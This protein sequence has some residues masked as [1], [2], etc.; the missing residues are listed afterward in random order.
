MNE[1]LLSLS[2][3]DP[4]EAIRLANTIDGNENDLILKAAIL[5]DY[6]LAIGDRGSVEEG[7]KITKVILKKHPEN[8]KIQYNLANGLQ[9]LSKVT[10]IDRPDWYLSTHHIRQEARLLFSN[11]VKNASCDSELTT[12]AYTNLGNLL[13]SSYRWVEAFD[14]YNDALKYDINN[15]VASSG[16]A[17]ILKH[18]LDIGVGDPDTIKR[19]INRY[20]NIT[21]KSSGNILKYAGKKACASIKSD[22]GF[23]QISADDTNNVQLGDYESFVA[24]HRLALSL[25]I[26]DANLNTKR[27]DDIV[28]ESILVGKKE[29][30]AVPSTFA[31]FNIMKSD[32]ILARWLTYSALNES[33]PDS[34]KYSDTL[35]YA[36][37]G[38]KYSLLTF[39]QKSAID[40][41]DKLTVAS[42]EYFNMG[43]AK[44]AHF[45]NSWFTE[46]KTK[47]FQWKKNIKDAIFD[48]N[49][50]LIALTELAKDFSEENGY[51]KSISLL[52]NA[53]THR[54]VVL[55]DMG[56]KCKVK[57]NIIEHYDMDNFIGDLIT[58]LKV[59][60]S[61][62]LYF[63]E[64]V[65]HSEAI[66]QKKS[67]GFIGQLDVPSHHHIRG[68]D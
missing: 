51:L 62:I 48:D 37:Y 12:Q 19:S 53:A 4:K 15:G 38:S 64:M 39:A 60:R 36:N 58:T 5:I 55:H 26:D 14:A 29:T 41:L 59:V 44:N 34:G 49:T 47:K 57:K 56:D 46:S 52:R 65:S 45:K 40:V 18:C 50:S 11:V 16:A 8:N 20:S 54:F 68:E 21:K 1:K 7:V 42:L 61:S 28:I 35:D 25:T 24:E 67:T 33:I 43:G 10:L 6:G 2:N 17:K 66:K 27:W 13:N 9:A 31:M 23:H 30:S 3:S 22:I 32:Y 63:A